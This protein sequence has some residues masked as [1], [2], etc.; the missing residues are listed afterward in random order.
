MNKIKA[1]RF[2]LMSLRVSFSLAAIILVMSSYAERQLERDREDIAV[3]L[4]RAFVRLVEVQSGKNIKPDAA[5]Q[6]TELAYE[7][8]EKLRDD[9]DG[10][11]K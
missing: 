9:D 6:L 3:L 5:Q 4:L 7:V 10:Y 1:R 11:A 2:I 8:I